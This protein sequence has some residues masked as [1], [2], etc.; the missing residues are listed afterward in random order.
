M[1]DSRWFSN[2]FGRVEG[3]KRSGGSGESPG[4]GFACESE[5]EDL[6]KELQRKPGTQLQGLGV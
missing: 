1:Q 2:H 5:V 3:P 6:E 4:L